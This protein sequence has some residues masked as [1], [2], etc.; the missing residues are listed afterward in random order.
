MPNQF[1]INGRG[2]SNR[3]LSIAGLCFVLVAAVTVATAIAKSKGDLDN[4][5]RVTVALV[6][7]GDG[8]PEKSDV[9]FQ[10]VLV[11]QVADVITAPAGQPNI[12]H[13]DLK[14][15]YASGIPSTVTARV[16]PSNVFAVSSIQLVGHGNGPNGLRA[17]VTVPED[18]SLPTVMF[19]NTL[20]KVRKVFQ[21]LGHQPTGN[22]VGAIA[23]LTEAT[24]G[25]GQAIRTAGRD[26]DEIVTELNKVVG[27][28][29]DQ[30]TLAAL[31]NASAALREV[32]PDL[33]DALDS[34]VTPLR[35]LAEKRSA[36]SGLLSAGQQTVGTMADAFD[37]QTDRLINITTQLTPVVGVL[38]DNA[39]AFPIITSRIRRVS[40]QVMDAWDP[41]TNNL[42][43]KAAVSLTPSR[44]YTRADCPR[45]GALEGPSCKTAPEVPTAPSL[46]PALGSMG[47][48]APRV[49]TENR[50]NFTPPR[51]SMRH[52]GEVPGA[53]SEGPGPLPG[54]APDSPPVAQPGT[55]PGPPL[56]AEVT[57]QSATIGGNVGPVGSPEELAQLSK[58]T[59]GTANAA[60]ALL[61][62]PVVRGTS[63]TVTPDTGGE[64]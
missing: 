18:T 61:L 11:G 26:L 15:Q 48:P 5:V 13:V 19:Q 31:T 21:A 36:L 29:D 25:R 17:G 41:D 2:P 40:N 56:P 49:A 55:A 9:K 64:S 57:H 43:V 28:R 3:A 4:N 60:T 44:V 8:L 39:G 53:L 59:G 1:D 20:N 14:P 24:Q 16:V 12:V 50:P 45:Y 38:G 23:A 27:D 47:F 10:G 35:T 32:S 22:S 46:Y 34:A 58:I 37:H 54:P 30:S 52:S 7:V 33:F 42:T 51:D 6:N 63:V 62:G